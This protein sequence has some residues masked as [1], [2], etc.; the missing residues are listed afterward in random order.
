MYECEGD[1]NRPEQKDL[2]GAP[3]R[4]GAKVTPLCL[5]E[6]VVRG[7]GSQWGTLREF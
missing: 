2:I 3:A 4:A 5:D 1:A 7:K 6:G